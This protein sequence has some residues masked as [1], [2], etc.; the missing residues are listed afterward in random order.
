[1]SGT[2]WIGLF[3]LVGAIIFEVILPARINEGFQS[4]AGGATGPE[5]TPDTSSQVQPN[6]LTKHFTRRGDVGPMKE[7]KGYVQDP[8]YFNGFADVQRIGVTNDFCRMVNPGAED[9]MFF[10]CALAGTMGDPYSF[11]TRTVRQGLAISRDDYMRDAFRDGRDAYCRII[12]DTDGLYK[13]MCLR[14]GDFAFNSRDYLD[15]TPPEPIKT[16]TDFYAG[17]KMWLR[18]RDDMED[19]VKTAVLQTA[20]GITLDHTPN[21][22]ITRGLHFNGIDQFIRLGDTEELSLGNRIKMRTVRAV[23]LWAYFDEFTNNAHLFDFGDGAGL[24][25]F[26][27]GILGKGDAG[28]ATNEIRAGPKCQETTVPGTE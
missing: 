13:P 23:S 15:V 24:N 21:P 26:F 7:L 5:G 10:A 25:N 27:L 14:A 17:C 20:G 22:T 28:D 16:L 2:V 6:I 19:Y 4:L 9:D 12:K 1:M 3:L 11:K 18:F 8:R